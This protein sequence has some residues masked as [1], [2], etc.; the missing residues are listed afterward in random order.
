MNITSNYCFLVNELAV[1]YQSIVEV[2]MNSIN[3]VHVDD[4]TGKLA[5]IARSEDKENLVILQVT[6]H[7]SFL[8]LPST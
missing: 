7:W 6:S 3:D 8:K 4:W 5:I 1:L 2:S